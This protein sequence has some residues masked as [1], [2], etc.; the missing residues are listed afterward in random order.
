MAPGGTVNLK[1]EKLLG[2]TG[3]VSSMIVSVCDMMMN[4]LS[5]CAAELLLRTTQA[6]AGSI[7]TM[8][9][10][11]VLGLERLRTSFGIGTGAGAAAAAA[12]F[13]ATASAAPTPGIATGCPHLR[14]NCDSSGS[15]V[16]H[17]LQNWATAEA[18]PAMT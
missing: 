13:P 11:A 17:F 5:S 9:Q 18:T 1:L 14:Q 2:L 16:L 8:S 4:S 6:I 7:S 10:I 15:S 3:K 12:R